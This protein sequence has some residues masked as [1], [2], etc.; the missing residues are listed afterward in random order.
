MPALVHKR[1]VGTISGLLVVDL[2]AERPRRI[3]SVIV[4]H[5]DTVLSEVPKES[6]HN[7]TRLPSR[8]MI[9]SPELPEP[10]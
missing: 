8:Y 2:F 7:Y 5:K 9:D 3:G 1:M 10:T 4:Y 6:R